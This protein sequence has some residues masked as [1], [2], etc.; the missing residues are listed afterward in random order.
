MYVDDLTLCGHKSCHESFLTALRT[1]V[2]LDPETSMQDKSGALI[3]GRRHFSKSADGHTTCAF[4]MRSYTRQDVGDYCKLADFGINKLR[5]VPTPHLPESAMTDD[6]MSQPGQLHKHAS[7]VLMRALWLSWLCR[8]DL[9]FII[10]RLASR[11]TT[12]S[13]FED[14]QLDRCIAY[15][16]G[17]CDN[18]LQGEVT[19]N[20][21]PM[22]EVYTDAD[23]ASC[24]HTAKSMPGVFICVSTGERSFPIH[25]YSK[26]RSSVARSIPEAELIALASG[27]FGELYNTHSMLEQLIEDVV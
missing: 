11:V 15:L 21:K 10:A 20:Q 25:W 13:R 22:I 2:K 23:F 9:G 27:L 6:D 17:T 1:E 12:W 7:R 24:P 3:L 18:V 5:A 14:K 26:K 4:D 19:F 16:H 8:P